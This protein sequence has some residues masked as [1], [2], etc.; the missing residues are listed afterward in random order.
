MSK[1]ILSYSRYHFDPEVNRIDGGT[2]F[3]SS[4]L[5]RDLHEI[6]PK[7]EIIFLDHKDFKKIRGVKDVKLF[8]GVSPNFQNFVKK[9]NPDY[10]V[11]WAV[12]KAARSRRDISTFA[13]ERNL[14]YR[15]LTEADG[16]FSNLQ[17]AKYSDSVITLGGWSNYASFV[18]AGVNPN[19]VFPIGIGNV[20]HQE[21]KQLANG[22]NI[23]YFTGNLNFRKGAHLIKDILLHLKN[24]HCEN[25]L[26]AVGT[27]SSK[28]WLDEIDNYR[29]NFPHNFIY[30]NEWLN[31]DES[32]WLNLVESCSFAIFPSFEEGVAAAPIDVIMSG[33]P[34]LYS[35]ET[36]LEFTESALNLTM[37][38]TEEWIYAIDKMLKMS[39]SDKN[40]MLLEQQNL[41]KL[42]GVEI[43][44]IKR[45]LRRISNGGLWP[46]I[47]L[48]QDL[49]Q[50]V[51]LTKLPLSLDSSEYIIRDLTKKANLVQTPRLVVE[52][53][54][55][56][57]D[58]EAICR[59]GIITLDKYVS[60]KNLT[61]L[62]GSL[63]A[64]IDVIYNDKIIDN[65]IFTS[66]DTVLSLV[67][68]SNLAYDNSLRFF[69][70]NEFIDYFRKVFLRIA[71]KKVSWRM[72]L[73]SKCKYFSK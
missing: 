52:N 18:E 25:K 5:W 12:N 26:I 59:L 8:F 51:S 55:E 15:S 63:D 57:L 1:I 13:K 54:I 62:S 14:P 69:G 19:S 30:I 64:Q 58:T 61:V 72:Y 37:D 34:V 32:K 50:R 23:F 29:L 40:K 7:D 27:T 35:N 53:E 9:A 70:Y 6:F 3:I 41:I 39:R 38:T 4:I 10:S 31:F 42:N 20:G 24:N 44:Q 73:Q 65:E 28:F 17:E 67:N 21:Y 56:V 47:E 71:N 22:K 49:K 68:L 43:P 46:K 11:L 60:L 36:G 2:G 45:V 48:S 33:L 66:S 16:I